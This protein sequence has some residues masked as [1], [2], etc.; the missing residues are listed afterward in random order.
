VSWTEGMFL[1]PHHFQQSDLFQDARLA[2]H[3]RS[4]IALAR[5][6]K[7]AWRNGVTACEPPPIVVPAKSVETRWTNPPTLVRRR[8]VGNDPAE[9]RGAA[10]SGLD[11]PRTK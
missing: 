1:K 6:P 8:V 10:A 4:S 9:R 5:K 11:R 2:Y 7:D 3:L